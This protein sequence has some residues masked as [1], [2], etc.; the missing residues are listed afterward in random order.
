M[1]RREPKTA[2]RGPG[3]ERTSLRW[4]AGDS[5]RVSSALTSGSGGTLDIDGRSLARGEMCDG[6]LE[7]DSL[8]RRR[9]VAYKAVRQEFFA[10]RL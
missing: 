2:R 8:R 3:R 1:A 5:M 4:K 9:F 6:S 10:P 7:F